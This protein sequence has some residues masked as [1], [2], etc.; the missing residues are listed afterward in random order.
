M[1]N[2]QRLWPKRGV[3]P[4]IYMMKSWA[5]RN[6]SQMTNKKNK[7]NKKRK[8]NESKTQLKWRKGK[9]KRAATR[10]I[11]ENKAKIRCHIINSRG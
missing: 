9:F 5:A 1:L 2:F 10:K 7:P 6:I 3:M 4:V 11:T 8:I